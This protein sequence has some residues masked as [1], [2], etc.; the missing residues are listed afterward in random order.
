MLEWKLCDLELLVFG[1]LVVGDVCV[2]IMK[3][4]G[5]VIGDGLFVIVCVYCLF[6]DF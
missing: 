6:F 3:C 5:F 2:G 1:I 4:C